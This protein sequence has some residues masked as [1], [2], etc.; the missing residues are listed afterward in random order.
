MYTSVLPLPVMP[1]SRNVSP[2]APAL[3][4]AIASRC[5]SLGVTALGALAG[6]E[7][8]GSRSTGSLATSATPRFTSAFTTPSVQPSRSMRC[9]TGDCPP[10]DSSSSYSA[11]CCGARLNSASRCSR[12]SSAC[13]RRSTR[14]VLTD[15][16]TR[17]ACPMAAGS[18][19][20]SSSPTGDT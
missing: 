17:L 3:S 19:A 15:G 5:A 6:R 18:A 4:A 20:R 13:V 12:V 10:S 1:W 2:G 11:R 8:N 9:C 16:S 14:C 7:R